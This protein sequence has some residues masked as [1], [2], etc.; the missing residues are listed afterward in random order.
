MRGGIG[1]RY[2]KTMWGESEEYPIF[3]I[4]PAPLPSLLMGPYIFLVNRWGLPKNNRPITL[5][6]KYI[7]FPLSYNIPFV[8]PDIVYSEITLTNFCIENRT[9]V[10][11]HHTDIEAVW[12]SFTLSGI[13]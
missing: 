8:G 6:R 2:N 4:D 3:G 13:L 10:L 5:I 12:D 7:M 1:I 11:H 9:L